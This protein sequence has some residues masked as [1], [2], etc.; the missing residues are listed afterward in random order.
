[1]EVRME[2]SWK[3]RLTS[4]FKKEYFKE[5]VGFVKQE[6]RG[7]RVYPPGSQIFNAFNYCPFEQVRVV[8]VGQ[9][10]YHGIG[11]ANGL[12]FSVSDGVMQP[13]SLQNI[14]KELLDDVGK[15]IPSSGNL[16]KWAKQGI[17]LL[18]AT[19]TVREKQPGSHQG[20]GWESF[21]D[22]ILRMI[23]EEKKHVVFLLWGAYA[24]RKGILVDESKH[25]V[26]KS[27]HPSPF[28]ARNG[29]FGNKHFSQTNKYL[30]QTNQQT[31][32]W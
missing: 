5:L 30:E 28:S 32:Y 4:E 26:L 13:P 23:S 19:L 21:T 14:F 10:P 1:M 18:N 16:E 3:R 25:L 17:L 8:I 6:Y 29:F 11:Q 12:C 31:I 15:P 22:Q 20:K 9:D 7:G 27:A 2:E 24:Q